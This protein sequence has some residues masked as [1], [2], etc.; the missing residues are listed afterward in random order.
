MDSKTLKLSSKIT[1]TLLIL[2]I[3]QVAKT[4]SIK[5]N[6]PPQTLKTSSKPMPVLFF[7]GLGDAGAL[8]KH[9]YFIQLV[10]S[11]KTNPHKNPVYI[12]DYAP[13]LNSMYVP[14]H[15]QAQQACMILQKHKDDWGLENGY[16][17]IG[18]SQGGL[19][20]RYVLQ[21]CSLGA[22]NRK[23][24]TFGSPHQGIAHIPFLRLKSGIEFL[25]T[26]LLDRAFSSYFAKFFAP[27]VMF[28][29]LS[30]S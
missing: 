22:F 6:Q 17:S 11:P 1:K 10:Q 2:L 27:W 14:F 23:L 20:A 25:A 12:V 13:S 5:A 4:V 28:R 30:M 19:I 8:V 3:L 24:I 29:S 9:R 26:S 7:P 21:E 16:I 18:E 15:T